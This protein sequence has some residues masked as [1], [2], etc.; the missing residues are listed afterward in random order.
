MPQLDLD[1][2]H[3]PDAEALLATARER[4][5]VGSVTRHAA[6][7]QGTGAVAFLAAAVL[8]AT[9][10]RWQHPLSAL[11]L[12]LV[13]VA[14]VLVERVSFPV[15]GGW[16]RAT[17]LAFVPALFL[18]PAPVVPLV[19]AVAVVLRSI[20]DVVGGRLRFRSVFGLIGDAWFSVGPALV[21]TLAGAQ[22]FNWAHWPI[23]AAAFGAQVL[24]DMAW[25][26]SMS[27]A[28]GNRAAVVL[29]C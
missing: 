21:I 11:R 19:A 29:P 7:V 18:L 4:L 8:L 15:A 26:L 3:R 12:V 17:M 13:L 1:N 6:L 23:Y 9:L 27:S 16:T 20:P 5:R 24:F 28:E 25:T 2:Y 14:W 22:Q 10:A